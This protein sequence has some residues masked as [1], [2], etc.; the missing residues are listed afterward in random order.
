[1][2]YLDEVMLITSKQKYE[3]HSVK[4]G[5]VGTIIFSWI[6][7]NQFEVV[8]SDKN[9]IDYAQILIEIE[10]LKIIKPSSVTDEEILEDLPLQNPD[11]W[12]KVE[13]GYILNL[14]GA[15]KNKIPYNYN[16]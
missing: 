14:N 5:A 12:C 10:D 13:N 2:K 15:R 1:M 9:G 3:K 11:W 8:F 16:S 4:K 7:N 6:R